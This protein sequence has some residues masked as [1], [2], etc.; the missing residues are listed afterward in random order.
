[1][2][3]P[4]APERDNVPANERTPNAEPTGSPLPQWARKAASSDELSEARMQAYFGPKWETKYKHKL[5][6]FFDDPAFVPTWNWSAALALPPA[7]FLYRK[8]YLPFTM[9][10]LVPGFVF[11]WLTGSD[12][13]QTVSELTKPEN[14]WLQ[15]MSIA[16][17]V[18]SSLAAGGTANWFLFR[19]ARAA[20]RFVT[21]Q[22]LP[23][24]ESLS[25]L[26]RMGGVN[27]MATTLFVTLMVVLTLA[28]FR[29]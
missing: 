2:T 20:S 11:R 8:L 9:F 27:R 10:F 22:E 24:G 12:T 13:P 23:E 6:P 17:F 29:G 28:Q 7:W 3:D 5:A 21:L 16:V 18:S 14:E 15:I 1:M 25:L 19:R 4:S 26:Q